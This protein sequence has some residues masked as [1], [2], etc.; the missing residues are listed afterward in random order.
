MT[1]HHAWIGG[2]LEHTLQLMKLADG[3]LVNYPRLNRDIVLIGLFIHD[4]GKVEELRWDRGFEY[5]REGNLIGHIARGAMWLEGKAKVAEKS[6]G[7]PLP[8]GFLTVMQ[9]IVLS[10]HGQLEHGAAKLPST[11]EAIFV[12]QLDNLDAQTQMALDSARPWNP[13]VT[14]EEAFTERLWSLNTKLYRRDPLH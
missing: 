10:H 6:L 8:D 4:M 11:P 12:S 5:T 2:L 3:M 9:H 14:G 1:I 7:E 13:P